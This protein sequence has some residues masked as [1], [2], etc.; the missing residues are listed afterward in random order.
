MQTISENLYELQ[1]QLTK[2]RFEEW[3]QN[4]VF[5]FKWWLLIVLYIFCTY[6]WWRTVDKKRLK[7]IVLYSAIIVLIILTLDELGEELT[8]WDYPVDVYPLFPPISAIDFSCLP[9]VYSLVYQHFR[10][11]KSFTIVSLVMSVIF[12]FVCEPIFVY[13]GIY[14]PLTW[15]YYYGLPIYFAMAICTKA[16]VITIY[17]IADKNKRK[18]SS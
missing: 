2:A 9:L 17:K 15:K 14:Q 11:W 3:T 12:C 7:E 10:T 16:T 8:L 18:M 1:Q 6:I 5:D 13:S 4:D